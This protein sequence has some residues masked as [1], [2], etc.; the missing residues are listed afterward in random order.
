MIDNFHNFQGVNNGDYNRFKIAYLDVKQL[1]LRVKYE[2]GV[3]DIL[4]V[5]AY[6]DYYSW[7]KKVYYKPNFVANIS[8]ILRGVQTLYKINSTIGK[9]VTKKK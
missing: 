6:A 1:H 3:S 8:A 5:N 4:S 2:R 9:V 7:D